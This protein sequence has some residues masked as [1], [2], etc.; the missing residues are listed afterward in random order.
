M[1]TIAFEEAEK[2]FSGRKILRNLSAVCLSG[3]ITA[4]VGPNGSGKSTLLKLAGHF[5][6][7]DSGSVTVREEDAVLKGEALRMSIAY[8]SPELRLYPRLT[9]RE[10]LS[11]FLGLRG[12]PIDDRLYGDVLNRVGMLPETIERTRVGEFSTGMRQRL[13]FGLMLASNAD[14][15]LLDEPGANLDDE[16]RA[17]MLREMRRGA[18]ENKLILLATNDSRERGAA[19]E[20]IDLSEH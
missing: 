20:A 19:D 12:V 13:L 17:M 14:I 9:A 16:G 6:L 5:M 4:A 1:K 18:E 10:N 2:S 11:F 15:W 8:M 3:Q 7:P